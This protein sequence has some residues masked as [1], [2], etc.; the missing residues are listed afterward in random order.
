MMTPTDRI[1]EWLQTLDSL[2]DVLQRIFRWY[3]LSPHYIRY[4]QYAE[5]MWEEMH[6]EQLRL[7]T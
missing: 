7:F 2:E 1:D 5:E 3:S 4:I 6:D